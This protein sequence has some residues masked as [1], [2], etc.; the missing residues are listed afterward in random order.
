MQFQ[1][2]GVFTPLL[3][4]TALPII[5]APC[6]TDWI[7]PP[8]AVET[9]FTYYNPVAFAEYD[10][11][12]YF[13]D[14]SCQ[15]NIPILEQFESFG[16]TF[17]PAPVV[18][19]NYGFLGPDL[20][21]NFVDA[22]KFESFVPVFFTP[23]STFVKNWNYE[24]VDFIEPPV[25]Y[26]DYQSIFECRRPLPVPGAAVNLSL[27]EY[28]NLTV[29]L[30]VKKAVD[31]GVIVAVSTDPTGTPVTFNKAFKDVDS[32]VATVQE[33]NNFIVVV[34]FVDVPNP[35]GFSVYVYNVAGVRVTKTVYWVAR[36]II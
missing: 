7:E 35:T 30:D 26:S 22:P 33:V 5:V 4:P 28:Y 13:D 2:Q 12:T 34:D 1:Y 24:H 19:T 3:P 15:V 8:A 25:D 20:V 21:D 36:G 18:V 16:V 17:V 32:V 11:I 6:L 10:G 9:G 23:P 14:N 27:I 29:R 31:S